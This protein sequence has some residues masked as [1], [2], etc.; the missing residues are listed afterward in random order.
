MGK[1]CI[2]MGGR[3]TEH[4]AS[5]LSYQ[6][7]LKSH[8]NPLHTKIELMKVYYISRDG[9]VFLHDKSPFP[10]MEDELLQGEKL[11][12]SKFIEMLCKDPTYQLNLLHGN[13]GEDGSWQGLAD[14]L[15]LNGSYESVFASSLTMNKWA[16]SILAT[17]ICQPELLIPRTWKVSESDDD[18]FLKQ[19]I[20]ELKGKECVIKPNKMGA[21]HFTET[22]KDINLEKL[23][24]IKENILKY[25]THV[26]IQEFIKGIE[27]TV[28][29][30]SVNNK[31]EILPIIEAKTKRNFLGHTEK[32][33][34]GHI[35]IRVIFDKKDLFDQL[36]RITEQLFIAFELS[37]MCRF[38]FI[39]DSS[40]S[41]YFLEGNSIPGLMSGSAFTKMLH[42]SNFTFEDFLLFHIKSGENM[43]KIKKK[44][45]YSI[46]H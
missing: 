30:I 6:G 28:G 17:S 24:E 8:L 20:F 25:D 45:I 14:I 42:E 3:S 31:L 44:L 34:K 19:I 11:N 10:L 7:I 12:V 2:F 35:D 32:H 43:E 5:L 23:K 27:Y 15:D 46:E 16:Q 36:K 41:I 4:D 40:G 13:E 1:Y 29:C 33:R 18:T 38:D 21:S 9:E 26:I 22:Y 37:F 39:V